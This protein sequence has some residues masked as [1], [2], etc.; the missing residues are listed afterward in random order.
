V[1]FLI[2]KDMVA[3]VSDELSFVGES[4][5]LSFVGESMLRL[6]SNWKPMAVI[7]GWLSK[8]QVQQ[9]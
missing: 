7:K 4:I 1:L 9:I 6:F 3:A 8:L 5:E 2:D